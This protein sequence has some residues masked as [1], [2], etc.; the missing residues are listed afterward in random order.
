M[1]S[2]KEIVASILFTRKNCRPDPDT[3][4]KSPPKRPVSS[5][6][7]ALSAGKPLRHPVPQSVVP[8]K[9]LVVEQRSFDA[10]RGQELD[11]GGDPPR[12]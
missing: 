10:Q 5:P 12:S 7:P 11:V 1:V 6:I 4:P 9:S 3:S 2:T 8:T